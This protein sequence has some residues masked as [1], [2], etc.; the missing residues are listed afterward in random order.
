MMTEIQ[1]RIEKQVLIQAS[2]ARVWQALIDTKQFGSWFG[3]RFDD[4]AVFTP[5]GR[6]HGT[7][8]HPGYEHLTWEVEVETVEPMRRLA[9][10]WHPY[11][12]DP[13]HDY[14]NEPTTL[15]VFDLA[16]T[17]GGTLL[18][19]TESGFSAIPVERLSDAYRMNE[20]GWEIQMQSIA[21]YLDGS[22]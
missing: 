17:D 22:D 3:V 5:G 7:I 10:R 1:D 4:A 14:S 9:W 6:V 18:T 16:E 21:G 20:Q 13:D 2:L 11:A 8:T 19:V 15:V 12:V